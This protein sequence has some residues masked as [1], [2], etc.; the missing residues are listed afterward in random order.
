MST[1]KHISSL[2]KLYSVYE[3]IPAEFLDEMDVDSYFYH[4]ILDISQS[5]HRIV[6]ISK[7]SN[8]KSFVFKV[9]LFLRFKITPTI[10]SQGRSQHFQKKFNLYS[11]VWVNFSKLLI[12]PTKWRGF[13]YP[14]Q[15]LRL[16]YKSNRRTVQSL[17]QGYSWAFKQTNSVIVSVW[18]KNKSCVFSIKKFE[19]YGDQFILTENVNLSYHKIKHLYKNRFFVA[20]KWD[21]LETN[22]NVYCIQPWLWVWQ[23]HYY[24]NWGRVMSEYK[25]FG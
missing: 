1:K 11:T 9:L 3:E 6:R 25:V 20:H 23:K 4:N 21:I 14:N 22:Y 5:H 2:C 13:H 8:N 18:K 10:Y 16:V 24:S 15:T 7:G 12:K 17:L 19:Q